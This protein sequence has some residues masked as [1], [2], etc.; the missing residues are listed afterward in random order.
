[1]PWLYQRKASFEINAAQAS[2]RGRENSWRVHWPCCEIVTDG[3]DR[4]PPI[5]I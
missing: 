1:V 4:T 5:W 2:W 3:W